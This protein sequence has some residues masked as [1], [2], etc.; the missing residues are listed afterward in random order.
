VLMTHGDQDRG[1]GLVGVP[2]VTGL[3]ND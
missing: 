2:V 1:G 3:R